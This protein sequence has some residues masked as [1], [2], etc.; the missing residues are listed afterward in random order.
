MGLPRSGTTVIRDLFEEVPGLKVLREVD[1]DI[2]SKEIESGP[3][4]W[5]SP[6]NCMDGQALS[7]RFPDAI[8]IHVV[9]DGRQNLAAHKRYLEAYG[10]DYLWGAYRG[11]GLKGFADLWN[12]FARI[13]IKAEN[14]FRLEDLQSDAGELII[15][16]IYAHCGYLNLDQALEFWKAFIYRQDIQG[17]MQAYPRKAKSLLTPPWQEYLTA[18]EVSWIDPELL[19]SFSYGN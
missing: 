12:D 13:A 3:V 14:W 17:N 9:R 18:A 8:Q 15:N 6:A 1:T 19:G 7:D 4:V 10:I 16:G 11:R 2:L 5:K